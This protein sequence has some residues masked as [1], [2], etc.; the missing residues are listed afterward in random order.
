MVS[1]KKLS[2]LLGLAQCKESHENL[3]FE[4]QG[5]WV[6]SF[7]KLIPFILSFSS[8]RSSESNLIIF[9]SVFPLSFSVTLCVSNSFPPPCKN[10]SAPFSLPLP[11]LPPI[12]HLTG[13]IHH[14][15]AHL[16]LFPTL[17]DELTLELRND[18]RVLVEEGKRVW[19]GYLRTK[20]KCKDCER[21]Q[22]IL[23][24]S[25]REYNGCKEGCGFERRGFALKFKEQYCK[26][27]RLGA[28]DYLLMINWR[29]KL[30]KM[31][32]WMNINSTTLTLIAIIESFHR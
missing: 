1:D 3:R 14:F 11:P 32:Y 19:S 21:T 27:G 18:G 23:R 16:A 6:S 30:F 28:I 15:L 5:W 29:S 10:P 7:Q 31:S 12:L 22:D 20:D 4:F 2:K 25:G 26:I 24:K 17:S 13:F 9:P 8:P